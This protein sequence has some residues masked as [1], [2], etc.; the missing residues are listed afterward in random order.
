MQ[1][2]IKRTRRKQRT[3]VRSDRRRGL[4]LTSVLLCYLLSLLGL[5]AC[6]DNEN[7]VVSGNRQQILHWGNGTE[8]QELDPHIVTGV[9]EHHIITALLE[10]LV[11]KDPQ[12]L[13]PIPGVAER[14][15]ISDDGLVYTF[16]LRDNARWSNGDPVT[17][18]D[19]VW[20][21]WRALQ[22]ALG[23]QYAYMYYAIKNAEAY[24]QGKIK[25]FDQV[26]AVALDE[27][28]LQV[29][30]ANPTPYFLQL[31][32]HYSMFPVHR[33]TIEKFGEPAE[34]GTRWTRAG[35]F[36]GNGAFVL[37][38]WSLNKVVIVEKNSGYWDSDN[39]KLN[40]IYFYPTENV[41]TEERMFRA[42][43]L[44]VTGSIPADKIAVYKKERPEDLRIAPYLGTYFY[45]FNTTVPHLSDPRVRRA[46]AMTINRKQIVER[47]TKGGQL[48]AYTYTPPD[49][50]GYTARDGFSF[51]PE[52]ARALLAEAGYPDGDGFPQTEILY[53][54]SEGHRKLAVAI[55]QM[56]KKNLNIDVILN[57]QDWKVYLDN[58]DN[59]H[60]QIA[61]AGWIGDYVDPNTFLDMWVSNGGNNRTG[62]ANS[63]YD[64]L[65]LKQSPTAP[66]R[67]AR[68]QA[69]KEAEATLL[70][71]MPILPI[72]FYTRNNLVRPS[73][74]GMPAN[75]LDYTLYKNIYLQAALPEQVE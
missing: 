43:Q 11:L 27:R 35:N 70:A 19:F 14:W 45:R 73:V 51:D 18:E 23:N 39:V 20:S 10:G 47:V 61:R 48:P 50:L 36:V 30:L 58:V 65:V 22:P 42:G 37:K 64:T 56:W 74:K 44:H 4:K 25:D 26:G 68:Y 29:T 34:R 21:W 75:L 1:L 9:P 62:W 52:A 32:D 28:T 54:T 63:D 67:D 60:Y 66:S 17:A 69:F 5:T 59:G 3:P 46:L 40:S 2:V 49:T 38:L 24:A 7:N 55:Q 72:Y 71:E 41:S 16:H 31:L 53:N 15:V 8:P 33:P 12:T 57:N 6:G 13:E